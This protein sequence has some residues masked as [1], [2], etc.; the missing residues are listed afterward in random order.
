LYSPGDV[1][2][3]PGTAFVVSDF[4]ISST[5]PTC[6]FAYTTNPFVAGDVINLNVNDTAM[7]Q[8]AYTTSAA[9]TMQLIADQLVAD[10][11]FIATATVTGAYDISIVGAVAG[12]SIA[13]TDILVTNPTTHADYIVATHAITQSAGPYQAT[14][15]NAVYTCS[16]LATQIQSALTTAFS[17]DGTWTVSFD[18]INRRFTIS[19][20]NYFNLLF[21]TGVS[22]YRNSGSAIGMSAKD[23]ISATTYSSEVSNSAIARLIDPFQINFT[24]SSEADGDMAIH[25]MDFYAMTKTFSLTNIEEGTPTK[26]AQIY[27]DKYG[28]MTVRFNKFP[29]QDRGKLRVEIQFIPIPLD[30]HDTAASVPLIPLEYRACLEF[31]GV[32]HVLVDKNDSRVDYYYRQAQSSFQAL[33]Q[34]EKR[35]RLQTNPTFGKLFA[36]RDNTDWRNKLRT[37]E[38]GIYF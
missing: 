9:A 13:L 37:S 27:L 2:K 20:T 21:G 19:Y 3:A 28:I 16:A 22:A 5:L 38:K 26:F 23:F 17:T 14:L 32:H 4:I 24:Q 35:E 30:L 6:S 36:R 18:T 15:A 31:G 1:A 11:D 7:T 25:S 10:F 29:S 12:E 8:V 34:T 33:L